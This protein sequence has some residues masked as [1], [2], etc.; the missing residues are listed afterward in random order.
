MTSLDA[1]LAYAKRGWSVIPCYPGTKKPRGEWKQYQ[2]KRRTEEDLIAHW[3]AYADDNVGIVTGKISNISAVDIDGVVGAESF[4]TLPSLPQ[5]RIHSTP[6][7]KHYIYEYDERLYTAAGFLPGVDVRS[8]GGFIIAPPSKVDGLEYKMFNRLPVQSIG[9]PP[10]SLQDARRE[11]PDTKADVSHPN[12][13]TDALDNGAGE[14]LR[15]QTAT[16]LAGYF[17]SRGI[18]EDIILR[19]LAPFAL[20]CNPPMDS[21]EL[22]DIIASIERYHQIEVDHDNICGSVYHWPEAGIRIAVEN[23]RRTIDGCK[24]ILKISRSDGSSV[25]A[26]TAVDMLSVSSRSSL[27]R[28]LNDQISV[29][30]WANVI[31]TLCFSILAKMSQGE[32]VVNLHDYIDSKVDKWLLEPLILGDGATILFGQGGL[33]KSMLALAAMLTLDTGLH[34]LTNTQKVDSGKQHRGLYLDWEDS[35][36][37]QGERYSMILNGI[38]V[39]PQD[40]K[41]LYQPCSAPLHDMIVALSEHIQAHAITYLVIDSAALACG[42]APDTSDSAL[43]FFNALK[44]LKLPSLIIAHQTKDVSKPFPFGSI[45]WH[46]SARCTWEIKSTSDPE[47]DPVEILL[48]NHKS[49][50]GRRHDPLGFEM[51][52]QETLLKI[53]GRDGHELAASKYPESASTSQRVYWAI[54]AQQTPMTVESL[55][56]YLDIKSQKIQQMLDKDKKKS[57]PYFAQAG[58]AGDQILWALAMR[59]K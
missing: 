53:S 49:N 38:G 52:F 11:A 44:R 47:E 59:E 12:W 21:S 27:I 58:K 3:Q 1:A 54:K 43:N 6:H 15:N 37:A 28:A 14:G 4:E 8:D 55:A 7:G 5:T 13:V 34:I 42:G 41:L 18:P 33:G 10:Q 48:I 25:L 51:S 36:N 2:E 9:I 17:F 56:S 29:V 31:E 35:A 45:F 20:K 50:R 23:E 40:H 24:C 16:R 22:A 39:N 46:N 57:K 30:D 19:T 26:P 32:E